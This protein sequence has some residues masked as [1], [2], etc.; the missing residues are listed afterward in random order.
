MKSLPLALFVLAATV[1]PPPAKADPI[2]LTGPQIGAP[3][4][5]FSL[6][7]I[8]GNV[9][10]LAD[11]KGKTLV[12]NVW[13]TWCPPCRQEMPD[14]IRTEPKLKKA[15]V[16]FLGVDTT[17]DA[18]IV[19]A[20]AV[21]KNVPYAQAIDAAKQFA[22]AYDVQYFPTTYVID[23]Q[24]VLRAR[25]IDVI[26]PAQL[27]ALTQAAAQG[28]S[29]DLVSPLQKKIDATLAA[30]P[31]TFGSDTAAIESNAKK[32]VAAIASAEDQL[33]DSDAASG[34]STDL[35]RTRVE[36]AAVRDAA[37]AALAA[38]PTPPAD[39]SL[40]PRLRGDAAL[41]REQWQPAFDDYAAALA[42]DP[43][44][45]DAL[46][47]TATAAARL[48][49]Y[50][51]VVS[52]D[53]KL[54]ALEPNDVGDLVDLA[55]AQAK[56]G[57]AAGAV[58]TFDRAIAA[59]QAAVVAQPGKPKPLR[60][61]AWAHLYAGRN[62]AQAGD[63]AGARSQFDQ[64]IA[65]AGQL[66]AH[67]PRRDMYL[68]EGQEASVALALGSGARGTVVSIVPWTGADLPGSIPNTIKYR[69][70]VADVAGRNVALATSGVPKGWVA[71]FCSDRVC[72][73]FR[74]NVAIPASGVKVV[75]FQLV[76]PSAKAVAPRVRVTGTDGAHVSSA[77]T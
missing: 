71:S 32:A 49:R 48:G 30:A 1:A 23:P 34:N 12:I 10:S 31:S 64:T 60:M 38:A 54:V 28:R 20:Y 57:D 25:Y 75:E 43:K 45:E 17:E 7:T 53:M 73:P 58:A 2:A 22:T 4:P 35:L 63:A 40:L 26:A 42:V 24:G 72:A 47:N 77:V 41:D 65:L 67:D 66:P 33:N 46:S 16:A 5:A 55:R 61:L 18:P 59:G 15:G 11:F 39:A 37:I 52:T 19:R 13:A 9:V 6:K 56:A 69:L 36:E 76:P 51:L 74:V 44:N 21:A 62:L 70:V 68:E 29:I 3:A 27:T 8:E 14:L 50:D